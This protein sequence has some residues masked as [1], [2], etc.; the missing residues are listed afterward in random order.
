MKTEFSLIFSLLFLLVLNALGQT[1][2]WQNPTSHSIQK[3]KAHATF[4]TYPTQALALENDRT[5]SPWFRSLDGTWKF[6]FL[7]RGSDTTITP[8][9][10]QV[11]AKPW[12]NIEVPGNWELQGFGSPIYINT[13]YPF[14][15]INPPFIPN[16]KENLHTTNPLGI[17]QREIDVP[18]SWSNH[19]IIIHFGGVSSAFELFV[20]GKSAGISQDGRLPAEFEI[21][22]L[23]N[24][25][26]NTITAI[27]ARWSAGS[28]LENQDHWRL[29]GLHR[30]VF[31]MARPQVYLEDVFIK[32]QLDQQY[33]DALLTVEP[34]MHMWDLDRA[35]ELSVV[36]T[37]WDQSKNQVASEQLKVKDLIEVQSRGKG[38]PTNA[39]IPRPAI[40]IDVKN[41]K[42]WSAEH[43]YLYHLTVELNEADGSLVEATSFSIGFRKVEWDRKGFRVNG[44]QV[45]LYGVNRHDHDPS[46]GKA[47][48]RERMLEDI[49]L[50]KRNNINAVRTSHYPNDPYLYDLCDLYGLYVID[51][52]NL[53]THMLGGTISNRSDFAGAMLD[54][55][56]R[57]VER[58]KNHPSIIG[59][60]LGNEAGTGPNH[61]AMAAWI[62]SYDPSRFIHN[63]GAW[64]L[65][66][67]L[68]YDYDYV[69]V[70]SRMYFTL[71]KMEEL[72]DRADERP[73]MYCEYAHSMG[74]S[75][76]HLDK[77]VAAFRSHPRFMGG[78]IW[79]WVNQGLYTNVDGQKEIMYGG[80]FGEKYTDHNFCLNGLIF[81]DRTPQPALFECKTAFQP[82]DIQAS[83]NGYLV[84]NHHH[85][86][87][88]SAFDLAWKLLENGKEVKSGKLL[89]PKCSPGDHRL[90]SIPVAQTAKNK[91]QTLDLSIRTLESNL[92]APAG[93]EVAAAQFDLTVQDWTHF[94]E[95]GEVTSNEDVDEFVLSSAQTQIKIDRRNGLLTSF[96]VKGFETLKGPLQPNFWRAPNDNDRVWAKNSLV[97]K[98]M[99]SQIKLRDC[100]KSKEEGILQ[101]S[102]TFE[103]PRDNSV[104][105][106]IYRLNGTG[107]LKVTADFQLSTNLPVIPKIGLQQRINEALSQA[108]YYGLGPHESYIDR[109]IS[110]RRGV[111]SN[112]VT[113]LATPYIRPQE[114]GNRSGVRWFALT[115]KNGLGLRIR[116]NDLNIA[117]RDC[118][119]EDLE[120]TTHRHLLPKRDFIELNIDHKQMGVGGDD[121]WTMRAKPHLED[122][123]PSG[124]YQ[125]SFI[126]EPIF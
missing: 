80:D 43:P 52:A 69:D 65:K 74:N 34:M 116:G 86:T 118:S 104:I 27:V 33:H 85:F 13:N 107:Q 112:Q 87:D 62:R 96:V 81:A 35:R 31:L 46:T 90:I 59:W 30:E 53:E 114:N 60:S 39:N 91:D 72:L 3:L 49:L 122:L 111:Y 14:D 32:T 64:Y 77:F 88:M 68:T 113:D 63:E 10:A 21:S 105:R 82:F 58:D 75:T 42:K 51:E 71:G 67:H 20:N 5:N 106:M 117:A 37:L 7:E 57:M 83:G 4:Y 92:W 1:P 97:W 6:R 12:S 115:D 126:I 119:T 45:I 79:D 38:Y 99:A 124:D 89:L 11:L 66:D 103:L 22:K 19:H 55:A 41:P 102:S 109:N 108:Q 110:V 76:G 40:K 61:E 93:F 8:T 16:S 120:E 78:F 23:L 50:M 95:E 123:I 36:A 25:G 101:I 15:P 18:S 17:Y 28:Y 54:R 70:R 98:D 47:V 94:D 84:T 9:S 24:P 2:F 56:V 26:K 73:L 121:T 125:F 100:Q 44:K 48:S 29:S